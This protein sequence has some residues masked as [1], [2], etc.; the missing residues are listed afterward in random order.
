MARQPKGLIFRAEYQPDMNCM[1]RALRI[2][3][4]YQPEGSLSDGL[5]SSDLVGACSCCS[6]RR[7]T[8]N[9]GCHEDVEGSFGR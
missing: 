2:L 1:V 5:E 8:N 3:M 9:P 4:E 6:G 7:A